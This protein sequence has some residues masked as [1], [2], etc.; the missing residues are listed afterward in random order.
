MEISSSGGVAFI[1][2]VIIRLIL[3]KT[4]DEVTNAVKL[5]FEKLIYDSKEGA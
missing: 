5:T 1:R 4:K 3:N 2:I